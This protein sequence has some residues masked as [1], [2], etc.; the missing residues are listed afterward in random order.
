MAD[1]HLSGLMLVRLQELGV[2]EVQVHEPVLT[3]S[4]AAGLKDDFQKT[5]DA[6]A[7]A[8]VPINL[9][10]SYDDIGAAYEW[11]V[12]LP[13]QVP[14]PPPPPPQRG[15]SL[16]R[17]MGLFNRM[18]LRDAYV[19]EHATLRT[20]CRTPARWH[21]TPARSLPCR[22]TLPRPCRCACRSSDL[23]LIYQPMFSAIK[24]LC[25]WQLQLLTPPLPGLAG[26]VAGFPGRPRVRP[27]VR[28]RG[29]HRQARL[30]VR[31]APGS[32]HRGR[33]LRVG[34]RRRPHRP[35]GCPRQA[36]ARPLTCCAAGLKDRAARLTHAKL[37]REEL[38]RGIS[39]PKFLLAK[40]RLLQLGVSC[41][42][43]RVF[44]V[45]ST[46]AT[47]LGA[48]LGNFRNGECY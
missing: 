24:K 27:G 41:V 40:Q 15:R 44:V 36:G 4:H 28:H 6:F 42:S 7:S 18:L 31:Q 1:M 34:R 20:C 19:L 11:A 13:V 38:E 32:R 25:W 47:D 16:C 39:R 3:L 37:V 48:A 43:V 33:P 29:P 2:P 21:S 30:P 17:P 5:F 23:D 14:L 8:G 22:E 9:V 12:K 26:S 45:W 35:A 46:L 10:T